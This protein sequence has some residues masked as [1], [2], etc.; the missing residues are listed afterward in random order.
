MLCDTLGWPD[1]VRFGSSGTEVVQAALRVA[2]AATGKTKFVRFEGHYH[3]WLDNVLMAYGQEGPGPAS[4]G[5]L[6]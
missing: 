3:G 5:Q 4:E 2:R 6:A 1:M